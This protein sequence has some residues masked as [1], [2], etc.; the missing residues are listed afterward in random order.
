MKLIICEQCGANELKERNG[1]LICT[2]CGAIYKDETLPNKHA[3]KKKTTIGLDD[4]QMLLEKIKTD[5][6]NAKRYAKLILDIDPDNEK[7][8]RY[9]RY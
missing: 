8:M 6:R 5:P 2:F 9:F 7:A 1:K 3:E 4:V